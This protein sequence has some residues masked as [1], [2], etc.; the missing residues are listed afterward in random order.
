MGYMV[1]KY[2]LSFC[3]IS[4][5][6]L[7]SVLCT[8]TVLI[9]I[10]FNLPIFFSFVAYALGVIFKNQ[11]SNQNHNALLLCFLLSVSLFYFLYSGV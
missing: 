11:F 1:C 4:F 7:D 5:H 10:K 3:R 8:Q 6:L 9:L 2:F